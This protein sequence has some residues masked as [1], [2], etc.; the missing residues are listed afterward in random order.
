MNTTSKYIVTSK[1]IITYLTSC[2]EDRHSVF[3]IWLINIVDL[4]YQFYSNVGDLFFGPIYSKGQ[5]GTVP[6]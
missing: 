4:T 6:L 2:L 1:N 3:T 5:C